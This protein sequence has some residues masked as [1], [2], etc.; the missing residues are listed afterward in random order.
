MTDQCIGTEDRLSSKRFSAQL[1]GTYYK[2]CLGDI[3]ACPKAS[4]L[5]G[6][7][8]T[9]NT[10][11]ATCPFSGDV[12]QDEV[13]SIVAQCMGLSPRGYGVNLDNKVSIDH[14]VTCAPLKT[15]PFMLVGRRRDD[16]TGAKN[17]T[18]I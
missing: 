3:T 8:P 11:N 7:I 6:S 13:R 16:H 5:V 4:Q 15:E 18:A 10:V 2:Q 9:V 17:E 1:A 14:Q 12:C